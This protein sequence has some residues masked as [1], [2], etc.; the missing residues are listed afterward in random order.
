MCVCVTALLLLPGGDPKCHAVLGGHGGVLA[1]EQ[2][3]V[4][5]AR[6][7]REVTQ[8][9]AVPNPHHLGT[10]T[11]FLWFSPFLYIQ[12][13][14]SCPVQSWMV[15][16]VT[17]AD[18]VGRSALCSELGVHQPRGGSL[19][20]TPMSSAAQVGDGEHCPYGSARLPGRS[21][22]AE[23]RREWGHPREGWMGAPELSA[24]VAAA[25]FPPSAHCTAAVSSQDHQR[26]EIRASK[27][28]R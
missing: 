10:Q 26:V 28:L 8:R 17:A 15:L 27:A 24:P 13:V 25:P 12:K 2:D 7:P 20:W 3:E 6:T 21:I 14:P 11:Q 9:C 4:T 22:A 18:A 19:R 5:C 16:W 23:G 1:A